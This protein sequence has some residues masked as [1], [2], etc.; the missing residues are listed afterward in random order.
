MARLLT[1]TALNA[2]EYPVK[3]KRLPEDFQV[4]ELTEFA[5][6]G[7]PFALYRLSKRSLGTPEAISAIARKWHLPR[8]VIS[9]GGLKD[10]HAQTHQYITIQRGP[11]R[12]LE[13]YDFELR[14]LG[15]AERPFTPHEI[16]GNRFSITVRDLSSADLEHMQAALNEVQAAGIPNYFDDQRFGSIGKSG[17]FI[18]KAWCRGDY[19]RAL[20]LALADLHEHDRPEEREQKRLLQEHWGNWPQCKQ[21]LQR[22]SRRSIVTFLADCPDRPDY[23]RA[24]ALVQPDLRGLYLSALQSAIW[25]QM[26]ARF[27]RQALP[28]EQLLDVPLRLGPVPFFRAISPEQRSLLRQQLPLPSARLHL[29]PGPVEELIEQTLVPFGLPLRELR[30]KFPRESFF[31][32]GDRAVAVAV[33]NLNHAVADDELYPRRSKLLLNF[34][35]QRG[36]YATILVKR[37][38]PGANV[39]DFAETD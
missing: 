15:Q 8:R 35:L 4:E 38:T 13:Q 14:Y 19:E 26:L 22:S 24:F 7:G 29:E 34:D 17:E 27:L 2:S 6:T 37:I 16:A 36:S 10:K 33:A 23:K 3:L 9:Y 28:P 11:P 20:W 12:P 21:A 31:S 18:A 39:D 30:V 32:K 25:N 5:A 1:C